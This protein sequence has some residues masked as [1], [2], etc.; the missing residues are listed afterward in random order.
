MGSCIHVPSQKTALP[1]WSQ[2]AELKAGKVGSLSVQVCLHPQLPVRFQE[3]QFSADPTQ[4][5]LSLVWRSFCAAFRERVSVSSG[6]HPVKR[7]DRENEPKSQEHPPVHRARHPWPGAPT[8]C[9]QSTHKTPWS[10]QLLASLPSWRPWD[11]SP[12]FLT[13]RRR[14]QWF[15]LSGQTFVIA[16]VSGIKLLQPFFSLPSCCSRL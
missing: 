13:T 4:Q 1:L 12:P 2:E 14:K 10:P 3:R 5:L 6:Y 11:S 8:W 16:G 9:G 7:P 15:C